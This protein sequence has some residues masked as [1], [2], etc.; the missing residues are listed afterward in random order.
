MLRVPQL[1]LVL[2]LCNSLELSYS[3]PTYSIGGM[4]GT[5]GSGYGGG[6]GYGPSGSFGGMGGQPA[7][8]SGPPMRGGILPNSICGNIPAINHNEINSQ[9]YPGS[10]IGANPYSGVVGGYP[11]MP[12][13]QPGSYDRCNGR[14]CGHWGGCH[15]GQCGVFYDFRPC[16]E[17]ECWDGT[18]H[19]MECSNGSCRRICNEG[20]C[21]DFVLRSRGN[22]QEKAAF[23]EET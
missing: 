2:L 15:G 9:Y 7:P 13:G 12:S 6:M 20:I 4:P 18:V 10:G 17:I 19:G 8:F 22:I 14:N 3:M 1:L 23:P 5:Y 21:K 16:H 11:S